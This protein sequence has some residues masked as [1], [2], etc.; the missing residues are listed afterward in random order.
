MAFVGV[1]I[2]GYSTFSLQLV[3]KYANT[4]FRGS[5]SAMSSLLGV[6]GLVVISIGGGYL[7]GANINAAFYLFMGFSALALIGT[8][9]MYMK[10]EVLR[11]L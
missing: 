4:K 2:A 3:N 5:V 6:I 8:I 1:G 7:M 10:S 9:G 11:K